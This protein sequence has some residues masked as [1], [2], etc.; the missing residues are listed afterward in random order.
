MW[1]A[2]LLLAA[3]GRL[4]FGLR[5]TSVDSAGAD[6]LPDAPPCTFGPWTTPVEVPE[7]SSIANDYGGQISADGLTYYFE[8]DGTGTGDLYYATR[9][10]RS[11]PFGTIIALSELNTPSYEVD[12][13][14]SADELEVY[15]TSDRTAGQ[16]VFHASRPDRLSPFTNITRLD[17]FCTTLMAAGPFI[18][19]DNLTL[20]YNLENGSP[21]GTI[22]V[23]TRASTSDAFAAGSM[24][25]G[26]VDGVDKG[27]PFLTPDGL[28]I[29][30]ETGSVHQLQQTSRPDLASPFGAY[31]PIPNINSSADINEDVSLTTDGL[32]MFFASDR[33]GGL[34]GDDIYRATR[35]CN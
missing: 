17:S 5:A 11:S 30:F 10:D 35:S 3:C 31:I 6:A 24:V 8:S 13:S 34:G 14:P 29:Y 21:E 32:E 23:T 19:A 7:L 16:C 18:T 12:I 15:F 22:M 33:A 9:P 20:Y 2:L 4:D 25:L 26:L 28:T 27:Y 1:R